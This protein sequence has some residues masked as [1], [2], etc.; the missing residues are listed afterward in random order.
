MV[1]QNHKKPAI[2]VGTQSHNTQKR[3]IN[4]NSTI[5]PPEVE[6]MDK[7]IRK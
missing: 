6:S 4:R 3:E 5:N 2:K 1:S 7:G